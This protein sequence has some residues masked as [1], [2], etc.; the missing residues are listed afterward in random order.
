MPR[1]NTGSGSEGSIGISECKGTQSYVSSRQV[2]GA[3]CLWTNPS[4]CRSLNDSGYSSNWV[5]GC[6]C[7]ELHFVRVFLSEDFLYATQ[8]GFGPFLLSLAID[9][10]VQT[11]W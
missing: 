11:K 5:S 7:P 2:G 3:G 8:S 4:F 10:Q 9:A 6:G 1:Q